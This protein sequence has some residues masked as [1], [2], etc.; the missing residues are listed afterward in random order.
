LPASYC[1]IYGFKP[2]YGRISRFGLVSYAN[3]LDT[4]GIL[5]S[6]LRLLKETYNQLNKPDTLDSTCL[7]NS[8][9][10]EI[11][12]KVNN[13]KFFET[14]DLKDITVGIPKVIRPS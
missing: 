9:R 5:S 1:G 12:E 7:T 8:I 14:Q 2:S 13:I 4:I 11:N 3:S 6:D 10:E